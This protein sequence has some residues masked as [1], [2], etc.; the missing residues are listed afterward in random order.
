MIS[1]VWSY[2]PN[3]FGSPALGWTL[4]AQS[5]SL[6][7]SATY[8]LSRSAPK[9]Q[10]MPTE[11]GRAWATEIQNAS[12]VWP[13]SVRPLASVIVPEIMSGRSRP[14]FSFQLMIA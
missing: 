11:N 4:T 2:S 5:A 7:R 1:G 13:E 8:G 12:T 14:P 6:A 10:F 9:A 3:A